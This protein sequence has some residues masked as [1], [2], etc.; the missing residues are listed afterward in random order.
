C[1]DCVLN[2]VSLRRALIGRART[3]GSAPHRYFDCGCILLRVL[4]AVIPRSGN[5]NPTCSWVSPSSVAGNTPILEIGIVGVRAIDAPYWIRRVGHS[6]SRLLFV[7]VV[8]VPA[9]SWAI[10]PGRTLSQLHHTVWRARDG[11]PT[12]V[13]SIAQTDDGFLWFATSSG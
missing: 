13:A 11:A 6:A 10:D 2:A 7:G 8:L 5:H 1:S 9:L 12:Y 3:I 4:V